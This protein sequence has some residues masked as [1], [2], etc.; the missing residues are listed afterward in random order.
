ML[1]SETYGHFK[2][3]SKKNCRRCGKSICENCGKQSRRLSQ[4]DPKK[5]RVCDE[6]DALMANHLLLKMFEREAQNK[7]NAYE[8]KQAQLNDSKVQRDETLA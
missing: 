4:L 8:D 6:C 7:K 1:C 3:L 5:H 2:M